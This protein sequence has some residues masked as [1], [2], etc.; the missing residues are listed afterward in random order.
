[1]IDCSMIKCCHR[2]LQ[3]TQRQQT[4][5]IPP[6][7]KLHP[8]MLLSLLMIIGDWKELS[9]WTLGPEFL[10]RCVG[11]RRGASAAFFHVKMGHWLLDFRSSRRGGRCFDLWDTRILIHA[12]PGGGLWSNCA[13]FCLLLCCF[14]HV[15]GNRKYAGNEDSATHS[16][17]HRTPN[18][19]CIRVA[20]A[21]VLVFISQYWSCT[22][23]R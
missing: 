20:A 23:V 15:N 6:W 17:T 11:R 8:S 12:L 9:A 18:D 13:R 3:C 7:S 4:I 21:L 19:S 22:N 16:T 1:M 5:F 2:M 14:M 10:K